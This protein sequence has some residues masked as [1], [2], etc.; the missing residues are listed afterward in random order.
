[1]QRI[2]ILIVD[3]HV[4]MRSGLRALL[5]SC[6]DVDVVGEAGDGQA[7][8]AMIGETSPDIVLLDVSM[9]GM[10]GLECVR[11]IRRDHP[12][13]RVI[14]L[15]MH[16]DSRYLQDGVAAGAAGYVMKK[17]ADE[18]LYQAI[19]SV[20]NGQVFLPACM[21]EELWNEAPQKKTIQPARTLSEQERK[22]LALIAHGHSNAEIA[23]ELSISVK[24][25]ETYKARVMEKL[26]ATKR[27]ELVQFAI[28]QRMLGG[29]DGAHQ[30][31]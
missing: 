7:A 11:L 15:T 23:A 13:V 18:V 17:S 6:P 10:G 29:R 4:L 5:G 22:V 26:G 31:G 24:T 12:G 16:E 25:V 27:S 2:R 1:M 19:R 28:D 30:S 20:Y 14:L 9:P 21:A 8:L 3:D